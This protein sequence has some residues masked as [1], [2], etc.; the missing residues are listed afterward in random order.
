MY[1]SFFA[2]SIGSLT[3]ARLGVL[4][5]NCKPLTNAQAMECDSQH[6]LIPRLTCEWA[7]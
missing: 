6:N 2:R 4:V 1:T 7:N 3:D 5:V